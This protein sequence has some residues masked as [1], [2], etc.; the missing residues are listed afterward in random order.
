[1]V[2]LLTLIVNYMRSLISCPQNLVFAEK[3]C[4]RIFILF[5]LQA[6]LEK[7]YNIICIYFTTA[8]HFF[9]FK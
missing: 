9:Q 5:L 8:S 4:R 7:H 3:S 6:N 2:L 1:M